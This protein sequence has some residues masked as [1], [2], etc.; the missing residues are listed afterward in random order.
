M[1][2]LATSMPSYN[3]GI[4]PVPSNPSKPLKEHVMDVSI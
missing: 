3:Q 2:F 1:I 4:T